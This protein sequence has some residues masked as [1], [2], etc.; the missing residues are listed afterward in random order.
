MPDKQDLLAG[1]LADALRPIQRQASPVE[2]LLAP[3]AD[4]RLADDLRKTL[5]L[6]ATTAS[7]G[8][9]STHWAALEAVVETAAGISDAQALSLSLLDEDTEDLGFVVALGFKAEE[10]KQFRVPLGQGIAG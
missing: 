10:V 7:I 4:S 6:F 1:Q 5:L 9:P 8:S 2:R 3:R